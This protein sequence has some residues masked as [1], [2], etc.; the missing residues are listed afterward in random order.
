MLSVYNLKEHID[1]INASLDVMAYCLSSNDIDKNSLNT[2]SK[3]F[4]RIVAKTHAAME[5][6]D[7]AEKN[8]ITKSEKTYK[9][10]WYKSN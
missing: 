3:L 1:L 7:Y 10:K 9:D 4:T 5:L 2:V 6:I 8:A